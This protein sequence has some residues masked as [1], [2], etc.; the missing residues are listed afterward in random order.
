MRD[1]VRKLARLCGIYRPQ[2]MD[3]GML[4]V[5]VEVLIDLFRDGFADALDLAEI[6]KTGPRD[7]PHR[8]EMM[9]QRLAPRRADAAD[10]VELR[11][12]E[13]LLTAGPVAADG[14]TVRLVAQPPQEET[15]APR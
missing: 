7:R 1:S 4:A 12:A 6:G 8:P 10:L 5:G 14:E 3:G 2:C 9:Q 13:R 15:L 11:A